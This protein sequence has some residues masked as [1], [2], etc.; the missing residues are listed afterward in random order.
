[1]PNDFKMPSDSQHVRKLLS[2]RGQEKWG[3]IIY[4]CT[5][6]DDAQWARFMELLNEWTQ[7]NL[8]SDKALDLMD[9]LDWNVQ[10]DPKLD[11]ASQEE[12]RR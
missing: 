3:F 1:M 4:R 10:D 9:S 2:Y 11:G 8:E 12:I 6:K 7:K 5:Y